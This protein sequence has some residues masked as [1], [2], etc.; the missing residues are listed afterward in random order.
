M[1][2]NANVQTN[3]ARDYVADHLNGVQQLQNTREQ[4]LRLNGINADQMQN[5][6]DTQENILNLSQ[7]PVVEMEQDSLQQNE[8]QARRVTRFG[9]I[10]MKFNDKNLV[11]LIKSGTCGSGPG[12]NGHRGCAGC[13]ARRTERDPAESKSY[14][15][16]RP[17]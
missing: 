16:G 12:T 5:I 3:R 8:Y 10:C 15:S 1:N 4:I 14:D 6:K 2:E 13:L 7:I 11:T 17:E 9:V